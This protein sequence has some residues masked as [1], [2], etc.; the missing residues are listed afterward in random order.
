MYARK[1]NVPEEN[2]DWNES[3]KKTDPTEPE[4]KTQETK[5][6]IHPAKK[7]TRVVLQKKINF[8]KLSL[9]S[10]TQR[11]LDEY[12]GISLLFGLLIIPYLIGLI[13]VSFIVIL[14]G[15]V[16]INRFFSLKEGIFHFELWSIG[17]YI[18]ITVGVIWLLVMLIMQRR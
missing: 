4:T 10:A 2:L 11:I 17:S 7:Q 3:Q 1:E 9:K 5:H 14:S 6:V 15:N 12:G 13:I 8:S 18:A 16:P